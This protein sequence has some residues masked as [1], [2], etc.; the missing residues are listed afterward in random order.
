[1]RNFYTGIPFGCFLMKFAKFAKTPF[2][3]TSTRRLLLIIAVSIVG[4][5]VLAIETV[6]Y[7]T[8]TKAY[9]LI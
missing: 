6:N 4:K 3:Q 9:V 2:L 7:V 8:K 1:M 5:G